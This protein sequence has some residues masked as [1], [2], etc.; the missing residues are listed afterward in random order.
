MKGKRGER[1][2]GGRGGRRRLREEDMR[3][4]RVRKTTND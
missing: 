3:R 2:R 1:M 4:A